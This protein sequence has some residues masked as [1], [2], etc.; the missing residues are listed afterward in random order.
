MHKSKLDLFVEAY[1]EWEKHQRLYGEIAFER[2]DQLWELYVV[3]R[4]NYLGISKFLP[5]IKRVARF[6]N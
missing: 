4:D 1:K 5:E 2:G 3:A 6:F